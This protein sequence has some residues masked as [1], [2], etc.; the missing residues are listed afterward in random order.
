MPAEARAF[1]KK[2]WH[3]S[4]AKIAALPGVP[5]RRARTLPAAALV[6]DR[7]LKRLAPERVVFSALGLRE[8]WLY[9]QLPEAERYLD[10]WSRAPSCSA[11]RMARVPSFAPALVALD[12]RAVPGRDAGRPPPARR[13]LRALRHRLARPP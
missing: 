1:A 7:V 13:G 11:C 9:S 8:G 2:L 6:L 3:L 12:R 4:E 5:S 10:P